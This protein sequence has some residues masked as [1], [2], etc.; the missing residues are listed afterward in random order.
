MR[1]ATR[2]ACKSA[3]FGKLSQRT[4]S[5]QI[6]FFL[7]ISPRANDF[8]SALVPAVGL[9]QSRVSGTLTVDR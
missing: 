8:A 4:R 9:R 2:F 5:Y 3:G 7:F 6:S 1:L